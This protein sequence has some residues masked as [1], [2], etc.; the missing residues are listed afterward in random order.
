MSDP[1]TVRHQSTGQTLYLLPRPKEVALHDGVCVLSSGTRL[2]LQIEDLRVKRAAVRWSAGLG[3]GPANR[4]QPGSHPIVRIA[5]DIAQAPHRDGYRLHVR[6]QEIELVGASPAGCF[7]GLQTLAQLQVGSRGPEIGTPATAEPLRRPWDRDE[8]PHASSRCT[9]PC[10]TITDWPDF[11]TRGLLHDVTRGKVPTLATLK[12]LV[13]RLASLK[14]NQFQLYM[15]HTFVFSFDPEIC[16]T[17]DG[18]TPDEI[19][20][21]DVYCR[22]RFIELVPALAA[23]G[24][25]GRVLSMP[26]YR[27]LAEIETSKTW[28]EMSWPE[29]MRGQ[30]LDCMNPESQKLIERMWS[31]ILEAFS[32]PVI[33]ICGDEPW[34]LGYGKNKGRLDNAQKGE[35]YV[36]Q[37]RRTHDFCAGRGRKTQFW[38]DVLRNYPDLLHRLPTDSTLLHWGYDDE[39]D[40]EGTAAFVAAGLETFVCPGTSGW[41]R[42]LNAVELAERNIRTFGI[43]GREHGA[44][45]LVNTDW[46]DHGHFNLL[47]CSWHGIALG[48]AVG[49]TADHPAGGDFDAC[50]GPLIFGTPDRAGLTVLRKASRIGERCETWR[51]LW[52]PLR[53]V[54]TDMTLPSRE[55]AH[56]A[57]EH[58]TAFLRWL[59]QAEATSGGDARDLA[60]LTV[61]AH[62]MELFAEKIRLVHEASGRAG[63]APSHRNACHDLAER[64]DQAADA[65]AACWRARNK[66]TG[67]DDIRRALSAIAEDLRAHA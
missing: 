28:S 22:Q 26:R 1:R 3:G 47:A 42:I 36:A 11:A 8:L 59:G 41:K 29:R 7:Y 58:A 4:H 43:A 30:T 37:L 65:Y 27:H 15:E 10:C 19:H 39:S 67:L 23:F 21:L 14:V 34:D 51:L 44:T 53:A 31:D 63:N 33:N 35:A 25:M 66:E 56:A 57:R 60:E 16:N 9:A 6:E 18:L 54:C 32:A 12:Q 24:H 64:V 62:F 46:G 61:A 13:D 40:Y 2:E 5:V 55:A 20:E 38:S 17:E 48:A 50:V 49:W 45:G 52:M